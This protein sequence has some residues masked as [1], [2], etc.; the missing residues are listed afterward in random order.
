MNYTM[1]D[2]ILLTDKTILKNLGER[3]TGV[4]LDRNWT[5]EDL[6]AQ[7]GIGKSTVERIEKGMSSQT[8]NLIK[9]LRTL[10]LLPAMLA[11]LPESAPSPF[12]LLKMRGKSRLRASRKRQQTTTPIHVAEKTQWIWDE[13]K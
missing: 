12:D 2:S 10:G 13:D 5:Q 7:A 8:I 11:T 1:N 4:R 9:I 3:L 6:A